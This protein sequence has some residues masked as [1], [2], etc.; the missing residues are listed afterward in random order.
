MTDI[1]GYRHN[2]TVP[3][4]CLR[5]EVWEKQLAK[6]KL[7]TGWDELISKSEGPFVTAVT[8]FEGPG[9]L[10]CDGKVLLAGEAFTQFRPHLGLSCD[11][12]ALQALTLGDVLTG[13]ITMTEYEKLVTEY[14]EEFSVRSSAM[15][16]FGLTGR[17]PEGYVPLY[18]KKDK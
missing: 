1:K 3:R 10:F 18:M 5:N 16:H 12:A 4:G 11:L 6:K 7:P 9:P 14:T 15:G 2:K 17:W 13:D 8:S